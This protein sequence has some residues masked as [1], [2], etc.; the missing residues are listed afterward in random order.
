MKDQNLKPIKTFFMKADRRAQF[1]GSEEFTQDV[2][3]CET[4]S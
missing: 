3:G 2:F 1:I 4:L